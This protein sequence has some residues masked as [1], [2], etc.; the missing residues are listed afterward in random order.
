MTVALDDGVLLQQWSSIAASPDRLGRST[1]SGMLDNARVSG[2]DHSHGPPTVLHFLLT[3]CLWAISLVIAIGFDDV[4]VVLA[5]SGNTDL[6]DAIT[7]C[8]ALVLRFRIIL[9]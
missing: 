7:F 1:S 2:F 8:Y 9:Q 3:L 5:L 6:I 4:S